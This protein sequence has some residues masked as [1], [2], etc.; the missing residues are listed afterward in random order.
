MP[1]FI[2]ARFSCWRRFKALALN[3]SSAASLRVA[4]RLITG[5]R[6]MG[7]MELWGPSR[8]FRV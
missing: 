3:L 2:I 5:A 1:L 7:A 6:G 8:G 4:R